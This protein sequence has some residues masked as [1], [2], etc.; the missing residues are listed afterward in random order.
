M[1]ITKMENTSSYIKITLQRILPVEKIP[2]VE[3]NLERF[4]RRGRKCVGAARQGGGRCDEAHQLWTSDHV[5]S[6]NW[7]SSDHAHYLSI[8]QKFITTSVD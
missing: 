3:K 2:K 4:A 6:A 1:K 8:E 7:L 5:I